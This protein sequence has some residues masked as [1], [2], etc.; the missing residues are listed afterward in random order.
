MR[1]HRQGRNLPRHHRVR[2]PDRR[3]ARQC[4]KSA[5]CRRTASFAA[6]FHDRQTLV[7]PGRTLAFTATAG[8]IRL[9]DAKGE[10]Q[11][12]IAYTA[13]QLDGADPRHGRS[14]SFSTAGRV[15]PLPFCNSARSDPGGWPSTATRRFLPLRL[16]CSRTPR[17]G[18]TSPISS[19]SIRSEP[20]IAVL[21]R[22]ARTYASGFSRSTATSTRSR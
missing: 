11:A 10:P 13:Y 18:S 21:S 15:R 3:C 2:S 4:V 16:I 9:F 5:G 22:P 7:L 20:A 14:R 19:S 6:G 12:D 17:P 1:R 8:S